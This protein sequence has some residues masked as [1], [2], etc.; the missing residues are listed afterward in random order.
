M[1]GLVAWSR[2]IEQEVPIEVVHVGRFSCTLSKCWPT[3][4]QRDHLTCFLRRVRPACSTVQHSCTVYRTVSLYCSSTRGWLHHRT[5]VLFIDTKLNSSCPERSRTC[6]PKLYLPTRLVTQQ[7]TP[8]VAI[9]S[10][11]DYTK[12]SNSW[13]S[14]DPLMICFACCFIL[15]AVAP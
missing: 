13:R 15:L 4:R 5:V 6:H 14:P 10:K 7:E 12:N 3:E 1:A 8:L 9:M 11:H 2:S